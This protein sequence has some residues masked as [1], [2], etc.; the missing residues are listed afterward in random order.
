VKK[1]STISLAGFFVFGALFYNHYRTAEI[2]LNKERAAYERC[3]ARQVVGVQISQ[4]PD[5]SWYKKAYR[6]GHR[7]CQSAKEK[8]DDLFPLINYPNERIKLLVRA[9]S[10]SRNEALV[11]GMS[12]QEQAEV[13]AFRALAATGLMNPFGKRSYNFT[14]EDYTTRTDKGWRIGFAASDC[15]PRE[16]DAGYSF[17]C[18]GLS[19]EHP[20]TGNALAD[21][22]LTV[23]LKNKEWAVVGVEG[24]MLDHE[25][26][27]VIGYKVAQREEPSHW[28]FPAV[29]SWPIGRGV[30]FAAMALWVGP[31]PTSAPGSVCELRASDTP[32]EDLGGS[33]RFYQE[34]PNREFERAG[35]IRGI[36][37]IRVGEN[38]EIVVH[39]HQY[40]GRGSQVAS[41]PGN[42]G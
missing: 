8:W 21:T 24:N 35:W 25:R 1:T 33:R 19:G 11:E 30:S 40:T 36:D 9:P 34:P 3:V 26:N 7:T 10:S 23:R 31:Y 28:E 17:T 32:L 39:C 12:E 22:F 42:R 27:R 13:F 2:N 38:A 15:Q 4:E 29:G 18:T 14:Y 20:E 16:V 37:E 5:E 6:W 41:G